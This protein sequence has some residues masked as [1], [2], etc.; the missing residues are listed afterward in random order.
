MSV[1]RTKKILVTGATGQIGSE[2]TLDL[3][4]KYGNDNVVAV[5]HSRKPSDDL[6]NSGPFEFADANEK[7]SVEKIVEKYDVD[8]IYHLAAVLSA[9]GEQN[10]QLAWKVNMGSLYNV[11]EIAKEHNIFRVFWPSSIAAFGPT[12]PRVKTPQETVLIPGTMYGVTKV[13]GELLCNYYFIKFG[14]DVRSVR[15]PGIISSEVLP[16]GGTTDYAVAIFYE[17][18]K[19][20]RYSCFVREDT[21]LPMMYMPDC[22]KA[23]IELMEADL[24]R[25]KRHDSYNVAGMSFSAGELA[26][27]IKKYIP[28]FK[29]DY[30]PDFRQKIADSWPMS[31]D[32]SVAR[33]EW[34]WKPDYD[35]AAMTKDMIA[36]LSK[37][38]AEGNL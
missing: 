31:I 22:I 27:E 16:T 26:A 14:V 3:R 1:K 28:E 7:E 5:G 38:F 37:R 36:K 20:K 32:D 8:T 19:N 18:V 9:T 33:K 23:T 34:D 17:A 15:Y 29:C 11:L 35:L 13:A 6:F 10:P 24:S 21:V 25:I 4:K 30:K 2:L 12:A